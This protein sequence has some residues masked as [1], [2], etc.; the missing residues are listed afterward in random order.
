MSSLTHSEEQF[1]VVRNSDDQ[2][3]TWSV[4]SAIP[5]GWDEVGVRGSRGAC[6]EF[7]QAVLALEGP[8]WI[9]RQVTPR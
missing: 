6:S 9:R 3:A 5:P 2:Y 7:I 8:A 1:I 4:D